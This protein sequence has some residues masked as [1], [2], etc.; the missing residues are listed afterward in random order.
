MAA[1]GDANVIRRPH[2]SL[3]PFV[4]DYV[5]Y[6]IAGVPAGVH[7]GLPS[8]ALTFI[9]SIGEPLYEYDEAADRTEGYDVLLAG[10]HL[11]RTLIRHH[12]A[13]AGIQINFSPLAPR[14]FF[15]NPASV[16]AHRSVEVADISRPLAVELHE[17]VNVARGWPAR[18]A[19]IDDVLV[20]ALHPVIGPRPQVAEAWRRIVRSLGDVPVSLVADHVGWSRRHLTAQ[21]R[22]EFGIAPKEAARVMRFN[23]AR[24]LIGADAGTLAAIAVVCGYVDQPHLNRDFKALTGTSPTEWLS[25]DAIARVSRP[26]PLANS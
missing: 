26:A 25:S 23:R 21:F 24:R 9:V 20:R 2:P 6:D 14:A 13:M 5:G 4:G 19:A 10:L 7:L 8:G 22:A 1:S 17:R 3:R 15:G 16:F 11:E 12:G 18:F